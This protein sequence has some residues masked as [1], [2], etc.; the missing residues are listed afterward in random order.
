MGCDV[1][2]TRLQHSPCC[3]GGPHWTGTHK[4]SDFGI[5]EEICREATR[6][7]GDAAR[8]RAKMVDGPDVAHV[9]DAK[10]VVAFQKWSPTGLR[11]RPRRS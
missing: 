4:F 5:T 1:Q 2:M 3:C 11:V 8:P 6:V 9:L 7:G 10:V